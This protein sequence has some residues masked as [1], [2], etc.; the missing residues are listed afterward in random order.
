MP[1][2]LL[3]SA[4]IAWVTL[5]IP[6]FGGT[7]YVA[8][9]GSDGSAGTSLQPW[10]TFERAWQTIQPGD[11]LVLKDGTYYQS[12][13]P[14]LGGTSAA[15]ITIR[16]EHEGMA[17]ID[18][19]HQRTP[20]LLRNYR[21]A[22]YFVVEGLVARNGSI[23]PLPQCVICIE[24]DHN[25][26]RRVSA[27]NAATDYNTTVISLGSSADHNLVEDCVAA[28]SG[29]KMINIYKGHDNT[30]R[31]CLAYWTGWNG[32]ESCQ[33]W[34]NGGNIHI[35]NA[36]DNI[37]ENCIAIGPVGKWSV[38]V[39]AN[40]DQAVAVGN[41]VLGT[42]AIDAGVDPD[43][44]VIVWPR[45]RPQPTMCD[46]AKVIDFE[47]W[48]EHRVGF[49]L[50]G[51][52]LAEVRNNTF[53]DVFAW[54]NGSHGFSVQVSSNFSNNRL[55]RATLVSNGLGLSTKGGGTGTDVLSEDLANVSVTDCWIGTIRNGNGVDEPPRRGSGAKL[56]HR[57][58]DGVLMDGSTGQPPQPLW[59]WPMESRTRKELGISV[60]NLIASAIPSQVSPTSDRPFSNLSL[61]TRFH[62]FGT[63]V[64]GT[65]V[66][67]AI[68]L[69]NQ[70]TE[71][72]VVTGY[73]FENASGAF[74]VA[75]GTCPPPP[76][77]L[78]SNGSCSLDF[79]FDP[80]TDGPAA[81]SFSVQSP[82]LSPYPGPPE[83]YLSG[84]GRKQPLSED[85]P[86]KIEVEHFRN[87]GGNFRLS[88]T[89]DGGTLK[90]S[91]IAAGSWTEYEVDVAVDGNYAVSVRA[92]SGMRTGDRRLDIQVDGTTLGS[93][94]LPFT[95][96]WEDFADSAIAMIH[97]HAGKHVLRILMQTGGF[98][99]NYISLS[100]P[101]ASAPT[102]PR[103]L[104][105][106]DFGEGGE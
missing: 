103:R 59:P 51:Q 102:S 22:D 83:V 8:P 68:R 18:G 74:G 31:R 34:P 62:S 84:I 38:L 106:R 53:Q 80:L 4:L 11:T 49:R 13:E 6:L 35:Y 60:T 57:Y 88:P 93:F 54:R 90:L 70:G 32:G 56:T 78:E 73:D 86:G 52:G 30:I 7:Y 96:G 69:E 61:A 76:F 25:V 92:A 20:I 105:F 27:Y 91:N 46:P 64:A 77:S 40:A 104:R 43:G 94:F 17:V 97:L 65:A 99:V 48:P 36:S 71:S 58:V 41:R 5:S 3:T 81:A 24:T 45:T 50:H 47:N 101:A 10:A 33:D 39:Q 55:V 66:T 82:D 1:V 75:N 42:I 44:S 67:D 87:S 26:F 37:I 95:G 100:L 98:D 79:S 16:A 12:L 28:G 89:A 14:P 2:R 9:V 29:R 15:P 23:P 63:A 21:G 72:M 85:V 19:Q